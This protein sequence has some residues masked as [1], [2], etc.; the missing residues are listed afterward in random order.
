ML[1][2][3]TERDAGSCTSKSVS[4]LLRRKIETA[5]TRDAVDYAIEDSALEE[6]KALAAG[7]VERAIALQLDRGRCRQIRLLRL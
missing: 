2:V 6:P 5:L 7:Q 4:R 1:Q 3:S